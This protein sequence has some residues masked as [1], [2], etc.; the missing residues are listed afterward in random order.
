MVLNN[1]FDKFIFTSQLKFKDY[2]FFVLD[3]P[4]VIQPVETLL[5]LFQ[6]DDATVNK[7][8]YYSVKKSTQE[9]LIPKFKAG[10]TKPKFL[11]LAQA[12]FTAS[13]FGSMQNNQLDETTHRAVIVVSHSPFASALQG[14]VSHPIDHYLR[15][16]LAAIFSE[17][18]ETPVDVVESECHSLKAGDCTFIIK[19]LTEFDFTKPLTQRQLSLDG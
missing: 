10:A 7:A 18:F 5:R 17:Y 16:V 11:N 15:G 4:F 14:K 6:L 2:N 8:I 1:F 12:F 13:G 3:I 9:S 19:P